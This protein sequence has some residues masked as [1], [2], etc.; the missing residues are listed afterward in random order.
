MVHFLLEQEE[1]EEKTA[2]NELGLYVASL[3]NQGQC[4]GDFGRIAY[5][6]FKFYYERSLGFFTCLFLAYPYHPG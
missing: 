6:F 2:V 4:I 1:K 5:N 3:D